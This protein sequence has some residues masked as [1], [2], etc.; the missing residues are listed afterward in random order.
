ML[1]LLPVI[2]HED[3]MLELSEYHRNLLAE[4]SL[5]EPATY[6]KNCRAKIREWEDTK[7]YTQGQID[8]L[9]KKISKNLPAPEDMEA[10]LVACQ[11]Q[12]QEIEARRPKSADV[13]VLEGKKFALE[14]ELDNV[15]KSQP[16][17]KDCAPVEIRLAQLKGQ[18]S[19]L[20][21]RQYASGITDTLTALD[22]ELQSLRQEWT[23]LGKL[24]N[25]I[26]SGSTCP[27]CLYKISSNH[28]AHVKAEISKEKSAL[29]AAAD[30]L[31]KR[32]EWLLSQDN[33]SRNNFETRLNENLKACEDEMAR[34]S[35]ELQSMRSE[36]SNIIK[37]FSD[38]K[39]KRIRQLK[40]SITEHEQQIKA[41]KDD[42]QKQL[43]IYEESTA[44]Q[45]AQILKE[46]EDLQAMKYSKTEA[47]SSSL[48]V[49][50]LTESMKSLQSTIEI[51]SR[52]I[53][54]AAKYA[55]KRAEVTLRPLKMNRV[56]IKLQEV[57]KST[58][59]IVNTFC[60]TYDGK[61]YRILSLSEKLRAG[62]EVSNLIQQLTGKCYPVLV[63]N[64]ESITGIENLDIPGQAIL[65]RVVPGAKLSVKTLPPM[66]ESD[67]PPL[68]KAG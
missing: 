26:T 35:I 34:L 20:K 1:K 42:F 3:V 13:A 18:Y 56:E 57:V 29:K 23:R 64:S 16:E 40:G 8:T 38:K 22:L 28:V 43:L 31:V 12:L 52:K 4:E 65:S 51:L 49:L 62:L 68:K 61:D 10:R 17:L 9:S 2:S 24:T 33:E 19:V 32:R 59:E 45:K 37:S 63:D 15:V 36:N 60:F 55:A 25:S 11:A 44:P 67:L 66:Q 39:E 5:L 41:L 53:D 50:R 46:R 30:S 58:G 47:E 7:T 6:I 14:A 54:A 21:S 27:T 48:E